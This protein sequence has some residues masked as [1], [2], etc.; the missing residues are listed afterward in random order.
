M[1]K[2]VSSVSS[3]PKKKKFSFLLTIMRV[4]IL[5]LCFGLTSAYANNSYS[6]TKLDISLK[7]GTFEELF[8]QIHSKSEFIFF[9]KDDVVNTS[10][11]ITLYLNQSTIKEILDEAFIKTNLTY[12]IMDRQV[13]IS[14]QKQQA[15]INKLIKDPLQNMLR[16]KVLTGLKEPLP[17]ASIIIK[18]TNKG[19]QTDF[20]GNYEL[21]VLEGDILVFSYVGFSPKEVKYSGQSMLNITLIEDTSEL[22]EVIVTGYTKQNTRS[23]TGS[24]SVVESKDIAAT[25][26]SSIEQALQGQASGVT[27]GVE[28][29]PGGNAAVRIRGYGTI[30]GNDPLY[31]I[32]GVQT[33]QGLSDLNPDD[34]ASIQVLK[35]AAAASIYGIGAA[36]GVI[37]ITTKNGKKNNK[38]LFTYN[39]VTGVDFI[40]NSVFPKMA[41]PQQL[42]DAYWQASANDGIAISHPQYG[43]G[44]TPILP[45]YILP[46]GVSG[47]VDESTYSYPDN[48]ITRANKNGTDWFDE[49]FNS[50]F[51]QQHNI[52]V[53]GGS[54]FSKF[55]VGIGVLD[56]KG[57]AIETSFDR[58]NL[59]VN[60]EFDVKDNFRIGETLNVSYSEKIGISDP[61][62]D[63]DNQNND[64]QLAA[65]YRLHP[66]IPVYDIGGNYAG[67][68]NTPG[69][70]IGNNAV[71]IAHRNK[72][73][74]TETL[75]A[76]G[77]IYAELD[78]TNDLLLKT[79]F[80]ADLGSS[81]FSFFQPIDYENSSAK[82][83]NQLRETSTDVINTNWYNI[84]QYTKRVRDVHNIDI[85]I[86]TEF[87]RNNFETFYAQVSGFLLTTP[88]ITF[89]NAGTGASNVGSGQSKSSSFSVFGKADYA[90]D[91]KYLLSAT[92]RRDES[93]KFEGGNQVGT[94]PA[95][96]VGWRI[97]G[98]SFL[99]D[100]PIINNLLLK[101][102]WGELGNDNIPA[103][104]GVTAYGPSLS[105]NNYNGQTGY[106]LTNI[107]DP[108]LS[109]ETT[110][111]TNLGIAGTFFNNAININLDVYES[112]T[113]DMLLPT[114][115]DPTVYGNTVNTIYRNLGQ[116][117]NRGLDLGVTYSN[118]PDHKFKYSIGV[119]VSHYNNN[120]DFL[121][122]NNP[123]PIPNP[124]LGSQTSFETTNT[125]RG[126]P[127]SSFVGYTWQ[128][129]DQ[130]TGRAIIT[131]DAR[132][133]IGNPHPDFT[134]G[135]NFNADYKNFDMSFLFQ[136]SQG[137]DVYNLTKF[138]TD[139]YNFEGGKSIDYI[140]N[141]WSSTNRNG[142]L[143][144]LTL[145]PDEAVGS[146]YYIEDG[147]YLRLK[148]ISFGYSL[149]E[150]ITSKLKVG[151]IR[152]F[153]Q[154]KNLLTFTK[155]S[156]LDP[157]INLTNYTNQQQANLEI[158]VDRGAY[159]VSR[160]L[161]LGLNV[162]F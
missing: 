60:S 39:A 117:T 162:T 123:S 150:K 68:A 70:G 135:I 130:T 71:A 38:V 86:G 46:Q 115:V 59:R 35:D 23:I 49:F 161:N 126:N 69:V 100:S 51:V 87:K 72:N 127:I 108:N 136:G 137:N 88:D 18:G 53:R 160:S 116:M 80:T 155:Y 44:A 120:V 94:F 138:W 90:Y 32:D 98:E 56:Q 151:K 92:L 3:L 129:I 47:T 10:N 29:G 84:L 17:G 20:D 93:S 30:N 144:A 64:S 37:I 19:T 96:S 42:A 61:L 14:V 31:V 34:I 5:F 22:N 6:Q 97:S 145:R 118:T 107:G 104:R 105:F 40:P 152:F 85:F 139:F 89:L 15:N 143:P 109:W 110:T 43:S 147:S 102:S 81:K 1:N 134:Y 119:N 2:K 33:G 67:T 158:G 156:G 125:G 12:K 131:G 45:D 132:D 154:G 9:Y 58:Y 41:T 55:Y 141:S 8:D 99:Q 16:G 142:S 128:G 27:V 157:E 124:V 11:R 26:P 63:N 65:L 54:E 122:K 7:G 101:L 83:V 57:V 28:G 140:Q 112:V 62:N 75:R 148:N 79:V 82:A 73:N 146:S 103:F 13:V 25:T 21:E 159:P 52:G 76:I 48:R 95:V 114:P 74:V 121:D 113:K 78:I 111:T 77:S 24:V 91:D 50:A 66:M 133:V 36:N 106:F 153:V 149:N 4:F